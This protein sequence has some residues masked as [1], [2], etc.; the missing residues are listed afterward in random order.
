MIDV[1]PQAL[2]LAQAR[3]ESAVGIVE[4]GR[5][6][7]WDIELSIPGWQAKRVLG[8]ISDQVRTGLA[9]ICVLRRLIC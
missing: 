9:K 7:E 3:L 6:D 1:A 5:K 4:L 2:F 8:S